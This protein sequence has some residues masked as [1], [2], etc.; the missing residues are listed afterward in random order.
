MAYF[1]FLLE[2]GHWQVIKM[3]RFLRIQHSEYLGLGGC[4]VYIA[5]HQLWVTLVRG[6]FMGCTKQR[7]MRLELGCETLWKGVETHGQVEKYSVSVIT[8]Q[9][10]P[11]YRSRNA[12]MFTVAAQ[13]TPT[14]IKVSL[15]FI[16]FRLHD[17]GLIAQSV[18]TFTT[19]TLDVFL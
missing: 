16:M 18:D 12:L 4:T 8:C 1:F 2:Y 7:K 13:F 14:L 9:T 19:F 5:R 10:W 3:S 11:R 15:L 17:W 6:L